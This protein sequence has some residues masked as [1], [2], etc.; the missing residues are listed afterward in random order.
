MALTIGGELRRE[1]AEFWD[2]LAD[3]LRVPCKERILLSMMALRV[4]L[5]SEERSGSRYYGNSKGSQKGKRKRIPNSSEHS[6]EVEKP[7]LWSQRWALI[8]VKSRGS[9]GGRRRM[10][11][12]E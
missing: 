2:I 12:P 4:Q 6:K 5:D 3:N 1:S 9:S 7:C 10:K 11:A 8:C